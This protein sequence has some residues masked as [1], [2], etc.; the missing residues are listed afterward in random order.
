MN[1]D[2]CHAGQR[3]NAAN[4]KE[5]LKHWCGRSGVFFAQLAVFC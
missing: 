5:L 2:R 3:S 1:R 4:F